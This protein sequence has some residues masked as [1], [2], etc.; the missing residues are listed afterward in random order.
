M[1]LI[2][3][4]IEVR[5]IDLTTI[6]PAV[7]TTVGAIAGAFRW[8]PVEE[9]TLVTSEVDLVNKFGAPIVDWNQETFF[10]AADFLAYSDALYVSRASDGVKSFAEVREPVSNTD[11]VA[12]QAKYPGDMGNG[13]VLHVFDATGYYATTTEAV[14]TDNT[15]IDLVYQGYTSSE[16][17]GTD[18][19]AVLVDESGDFSGTPGSVLEVY[20]DLSSTPGTTD[21][22]GANKYFIS[23]INDQSNYVEIP[24]GFDLTLY[25]GYVAAKLGN[26]TNGNGEATISMSVLQDAYDVY[27]SAD[28]I[29]IAIL[30]AGKAR[31]DIYHT[32]MAN[33]LIDNI[34]HARKD[35]VLCISP[36]KEA[37]VDN[38]TGELTDIMVFRTGRAPGSTNV[39]ATPVTN[40]SYTVIDTGYKYRYDRY[41]D[42]YCWVPLNGDIGGLMAYTDDVRDPWWSPAG[43]NR[44]LLKNVVKL[45]YNPRQ[46]DR[47][48]LYQAGVNPVITQVGQG[49]L[50]FGDK[51]G[52]A[53]PSAFDRINV[54]RLFIVLEK[55][56]KE[57]SR[58]FLF[59]FNDDFTRQQF[60]NIVEPYLRD[61]QGRRG[62]YD[63]RVVC[64]ETNN[65]PEVIDSNRF[66]GDIYI[67]PARSINF[68][69]L[70][71][72]AVRT[73][74]EFTEIVGNVG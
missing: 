14:V 35:V 74:V 24:D 50:L 68:I 48:V 6:I 69:R 16:P 62:I 12:V 13:L 70:N 46:A 30:L 18:F 38:N 47:D 5:E 25:S 23:V 64:D 19:H 32:D 67:K 42:T 63:F 37:V 49:T 54:R 36:N 60:V 55:A 45:A 34:A 31:G 33:Y 1:T 51:T 8:G 56:I 66:I 40:S 26:G 11:V 65:T 4:G 7:Q 61:I 58:Q 43:Y 17:E 57:A 15:T 73:G 53:K 41:N 28:N 39:V 10:T 29:D 27:D 52:L 3:P 9:A 21:A 2:S 22:Q 20:E 71:F 59:E 72:I 44:G